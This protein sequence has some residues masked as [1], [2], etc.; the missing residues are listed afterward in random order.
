VLIVMFDVT[1]RGSYNAALQLHKEFKRL[2]MGVQVPTIFVGN[3]I[4]E[5]VNR[6][7]FQNQKAWGY[8]E[9][10][11]VPV[12]YA[13]ENFIPYVEVDV[14]YD[15]NVRGLFLEVAKMVMKEGVL[16]FPIL[17]RKQ[18]NPDDLIK[19]TTDLLDNNE[20]MDKTRKMLKVALATVPTYDEDDVLLKITVPMI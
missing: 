12:R 14:R 16:R 13:E 15:Y 10:E 4:M 5:D 18:Q 3:K 11:P 9:Y 8:D 2:F 6:L 17:D 1:C 7:R 19:L 20:K